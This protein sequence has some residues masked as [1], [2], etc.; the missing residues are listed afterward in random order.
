MRKLSICGGLNGGCGTEVYPIKSE[1][2]MNAANIES[3]KNDPE[4]AIQYTIWF[5]EQLNDV[6]KLHDTVVDKYLTLELKYHS[7][8]VLC[9]ILAGYI[10][11]LKIQ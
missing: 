8:V 9:I 3:F 7:L 1:N 6:V 11:A 5:V 4:G 2:I 10:L